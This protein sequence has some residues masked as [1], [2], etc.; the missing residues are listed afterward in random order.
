[1]VYSQILSMNTD[2]LQNIYLVKIVY[3]EIYAKEN[4]KICYIG[5]T[6]KYRERWKRFL[7]V[8]FDRPGGLPWFN[9]NDD[10]MVIIIIF[11]CSV[12]VSCILYPISCI[13]CPLS[14]IL[15]PAACIPHPVL[16][17]FCI[18]ATF[19]L[20]YRVSCIL[21]PVCCIIK[22]FVVSCIV[23]LVFCIQYAVFQQLVVSCIV[24]LVFCI[25]YS[26]SCIFPAE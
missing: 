11:Q 1:M 15:N 5:N 13:V 16:C 21:Y 12:F 19:R 23:Y 25:L 18:T 6:F 10:C 14:G 17:K 9:I 22:Q 8:N 26:V 24:Y 20:L 2:L 7:M 3:F 4:F